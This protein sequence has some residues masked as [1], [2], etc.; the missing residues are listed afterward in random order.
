MYVYECVNVCAFVHQ[1]A[2]V[3]KYAYEK[4]LCMHMYIY[5]LCSM[6]FCFFV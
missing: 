3:Y 2:Y 1:Y 6:F 4:T 5:I